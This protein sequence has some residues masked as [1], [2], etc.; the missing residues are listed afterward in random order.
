VSFGVRLRSLTSD[1]ALYGVASAA[2]RF[3]T[4]LLTPLYTNLLSP[5]DLGQISLLY[6]YIAPV[7]VLYGLGLEGAYLRF[8]A[9]DEKRDPREVFSTP[10][11]FLFLVG[12][13]AS[14]ALA[15]L[16][17]PVAGLIG[18][19]DR[20]PWIVAAAGILLLDTL[21]VLPL[22]Y[23]RLMRKPRAF[24]AVKLG[25]IALNVALSIVLL[26]VL[27]H[28]PAAILE[29]NLVSSA[30]ALA[31][32]LPVYEKLLRPLF[33]RPLL[34]ELLGFGL[35]LVPS[36]LAALVVQIADRPILRALTDDATV[37]IYQANYRLGIVMMVLVTVF[38]FAWQPFFLQRA[39]D[40]DARTLFARVLT[41]Y[42]A[43]ATGLF[44]AVAFFV[45]RIVALPIGGGRHLID[46]RY[47]S[48]LA[49]VP[50][51]LLG[52]LALGVYTF[53]T[54]GPMLA[55]RSGLFPWVTGAAALTNVAACLVLIPRAGIVGAA[56]A[57]TLAYLVMAGLL[58]LVAR[59]VYP[60]PCE[61]GR[62]ARVAAAGGLAFAG[63]AAL[64]GSTTGLGLRVGLFALYP[65]ILLF[66]G[67]LLPGERRALS[68]RT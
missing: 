18:L 7:L 24:A 30:L 36:G 51:V 67:F 40:A 15:L 59:R 6:A 41:Y 5:A 9:P 61:W 14:L 65:A 27:G 33:R 62:L 47:W 66:T 34:R 48:G 22:A 28:G 2:A 31:M 37:G 20:A 38:Q 57:T 45:D 43:A 35:P 56:Q 52:Y 13:I 11:L 25:S 19:P 1:A 60:V 55:K 26:A 3:L 49:V 32:L 21:Q 12:P 4:F 44:L 17:A 8:A 23:L 29:A 39:G 16:A 68:R 42:L 46:P 50:W 63:F 53:L 64:G 54:A 58:W 10:T